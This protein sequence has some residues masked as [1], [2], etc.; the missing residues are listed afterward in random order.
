[1]SGILGRKRRN[2]ELYGKEDF[3]YDGERD[4]YVC[5]AGE[6]LSP[7]VKSRIETKYSEREVMI[8]RAQRG[9]CLSCEQKARCTTTNNKVGR[10]VSRDRYERVR[11]QMRQKL[12]T[13]VGREIYGKRKYLIEP[14]FG[15]IKMTEKFIQFL[16]RG[17]E[18]VK[19]EWKW[20]AIVHNL[21]K[22]IRKVRTR[23]LKLAGVA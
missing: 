2:P 17:L 19:I 20:A 7:R 11:A 5:P 9:I 23:E 3:K 10:A 6:V 8:Y 18:R 14:V 16:L 15:Q 1:M 22:I 12:K 21:L 4:C 13:E